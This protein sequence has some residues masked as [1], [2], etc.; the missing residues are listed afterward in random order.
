MMPTA[1]SKINSLKASFEKEKQN[2][3]EEAV[4]QATEKTKSSVKET[5]EKDYKAKLESI[6]KERQA[7]LDKAKQLAIKLDKNADADLVTATL[8]FNELQSHL[9]KF[10]NSV[11][12]ICETNSAQG[13]KLKQIAQNFLSNTIANLN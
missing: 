1:K 4:K 11:E 8:Y 3:V 12:K 2:A 9:K 13:E 6:E 7:A 5:L 10:I